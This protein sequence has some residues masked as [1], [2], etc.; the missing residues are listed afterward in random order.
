MLK[1]AYYVYRFAKCTLWMWVKDRFYVKKEH[2]AFSLS[3]SSFLQCIC[4]TTRQQWNF[5]KECKSL[6]YNT[7]SNIKPHE[8]SQ[9]DCSILETI[10]FAKI[11]K[12]FAD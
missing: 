8:N 6:P 11:Y 9:I 5:R 2:F 7:I 1:Y 10:V 4:N 3:L 12:F